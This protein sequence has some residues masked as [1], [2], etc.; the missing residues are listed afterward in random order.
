MYALFVIWDFTKL[1]NIIT[2]FLGCD[3]TFNIPRQI[4][5]YRHKYILK[6]TLIQHQALLSLMLFHFL[7]I[8]DWKHPQILH[9]N[10]V[11][12]CFLLLHQGQA[13]TWCLRWWVGEWLSVALHEGAAWC[14][15]DTKK[16]GRKD[17]HR[18]CTPRQPSAPKPFL[19]ET[20]PPLQSPMELS[21]HLPRLLLT[22][23]FK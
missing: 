16:K 8:S 10:L 5:K 2:L 12:I 11:L 19:W 23:Y 7:Q 21:I 3:T 14:Q 22:C 13:P 17:C 9:H 20:A 15:G 4:K 18:A 1:Y 6:K